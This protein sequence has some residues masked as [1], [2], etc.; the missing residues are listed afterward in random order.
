MAA[1]ALVALLVGLINLGRF[2]VYAEGEGIYAMQAWS[3]LHGRLSPYSYWYDH[4]FV[5]WVQMSPFM[6]LGRW[7][8]PA[9]SPVVAA[10]LA[11]VV[12]L[13]VDAALLFVIARRLRLGR[14]TAVLA[15]A[16]FVLSPLVQSEMRRAFLDNMS[17]PWLL[18][19]VA[20]A[21]SVRSWNSG[22]IGSGVCFAIAVLSKETSLLL[23]PVVLLAIASR[24][25]RAERR[26]AVRAAVWSFTAVAGLYPLYALL[27][28]QLFPV[29][30]RTSLVRA[31]K[32]QLADRTGSGSLFSRTSSRQH[33][34]LYWLSRDR[35]LIVAGVAAAVILLL[36][37]PRLCP[38]ALGVLIPAAWVLRPGG[39][40]PVMFVIVALP[41]L[42]LAI[43]AASEMLLGL[44]V[45]LARRAIDTEGAGAAA[46][47]G[48]LSATLLLATLPAQ[49]RLHA[50][51]VFVG[52]SNRLPEQATAWIAE[53]VPTSQRL[54][55]D[56]VLWI[57]LAAAG[58]TDPWQQVVWLYKLDTDPVAASRLP[59]GWRD[60]DYVV[61]TRT[62][63]HQLDSDPNLVQCRRALRHSTVVRTF[64]GGVDR[65]EVRRVVTRRQ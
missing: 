52:Q 3:V 34:V 37:V 38:V 29:P 17:M 53:H 35:F 65:I 43:A 40:L 47:A 2:P 58:W 64:G 7:L 57:D 46:T 33:E 42:A 26:P 16:L 60:I 18:A 49:Q 44:V 1:S 62:L 13:A 9:T 48:W 51:D 31:L 32:W 41:F 5:G 63:R 19:A 50:S 25:D 6:A 8:M 15:V 59:A 39:Y 14:C 28:G 61:S 22:A 20:V 12:A 55:V 10:R 30:G 54:L 24:V 21:L 11:A 23:A 36:A 27:R 45:R 56:D 4:P